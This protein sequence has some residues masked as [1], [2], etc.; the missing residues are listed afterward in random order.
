M[1]VHPLR[2]RLPQRPLWPRRASLLAALVL[3]LAGAGRAGAQDAA[4]REGAHVFMESHCFVCHGEMGNGGA[5]PSF[6]D[7]RFLGI[8]DYVIAQILIGRGIMPSFADK[9]SDGQIA[10]VATYIRTSWGND[11]GAVKP[12]Q[13][14]QARKRI[15]GEEAHMGSSEPRPGQTP[16]PPP[17][18]QK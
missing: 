11:F 9:L 10:A 7:D 12:E 3:S 8:T 14:A 2:P 1:R 13:V 17:E 4:H 5:G 15:K 6:R 16:N 18:N